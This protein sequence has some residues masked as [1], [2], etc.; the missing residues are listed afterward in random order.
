MGRVSL[1]S[2]EL[3]TEICR[4]MSNGESLAKICE[5]DGMPERT[6]VLEWRRIHKEFDAIYTKARQDQ[7]DYWVD[8]I[9]SEVDR[10]SADKTE[11]MD[12]RIKIETLKWIACKFYPKAYGEKVTQEITGA[13]GGPIA[14]RAVDGPPQETREEWIARKAKE[15]LNGTTNGIKHL[16]TAGRT[17]NGAA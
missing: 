13:D 16:D 6:V 14:L 11:A 2:M 17:T 8:E 3:V 7:A 9:I 1:Y 10:K 15:R 4:R 5:T 12:K